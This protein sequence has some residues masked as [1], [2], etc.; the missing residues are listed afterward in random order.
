MHQKFS[1]H[2][3]R[4]FATCFLPLKPNT[5]AGRVFIG[6]TR[7]N[8]TGGTLGFP[9]RIAARLRSKEKLQWQLTVPGSCTQPGVSERPSVKRV[10]VDDLRD[11]GNSRIARG[12]LYSSLKP[13]TAVE[14]VERPIFTITSSFSSNFLPLHQFRPSKQHDGNHSPH[15][16]RY[17][18]SRLLLCRS[19]NTVLA[20]RCC[21]HVHAV[22]FVF[23]L[24]N[25]LI[26]SSARRWLVP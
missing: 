22:C 1:S 20:N 21:E 25:H 11:L 15:H 16:Q 6:R 13:F 3:T 24:N 12:R 2:K 10:Y 14:S 19:C 5:Q 26:D 7:T 8:D 23:E 9:L 4:L 17:P 18:A